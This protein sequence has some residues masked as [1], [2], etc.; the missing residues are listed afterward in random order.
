VKDANSG[1]AGGSARHAQGVSAIAGLR[2]SSFGLLQV[3]TAQ[4]VAANQGKYMSHSDITRLVNKYGGK[5][6]RKVSAFTDV[7]VMGDVRVACGPHRLKAVKEDW[8]DTAKGRKLIKEVSLKAVHD[9]RTRVL[10]ETRLPVCVCICV[11]VTSD[12]Q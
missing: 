4:A 6:R 9:R 10:E 3:N 12:Q 11:C 2:F 8:L 1:S 5:Y 7:I